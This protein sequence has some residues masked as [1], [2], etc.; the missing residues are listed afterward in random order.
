[1]RNG[2]RTVRKVTHLV[3]KVL[4][5]AE[6]AEGVKYPL[7]HER[8]SLLGLARKVL[9]MRNMAN[10]CDGCGKFGATKSQYPVIGSGRFETLA[11]CLRCHNAQ[12]DLIAAAEA[13]KPARPE[14]L[15]DPDTGEMLRWDEAMCVW[16][17]AQ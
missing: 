6:S 3:R 1:M 9:S 13:A 8:S 14:L 7:L 4:R 10:K 2:L 16:V 17:V 11:M 15:Q 12:C 5:T